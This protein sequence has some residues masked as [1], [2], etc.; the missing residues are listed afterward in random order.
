MLKQDSSPTDLYFQRHH[1]A[2]CLFRLKASLRVSDSDIAK[3]TGV[4]EQAIRE[5]G[6]MKWQGDPLAMLERLARAFVPADR[7]EGKRR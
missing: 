4:S 6:Q 2:E 3:A 1:V 7:L 5:A